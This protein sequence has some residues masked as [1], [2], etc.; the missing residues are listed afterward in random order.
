MNVCEVGFFLT[1][2]VCIQRNFFLWWF[3][4]SFVVFWGEGSLKKSV[5]LKNSKFCSNRRILLQPYFLDIM[6]EYIVY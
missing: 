6:V 2:F 3:F 4:F 1:F 5:V